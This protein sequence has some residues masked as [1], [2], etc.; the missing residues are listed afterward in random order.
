LNQNVA[1]GHAVNNPSVVVTFPTDESNASKSA[2]IQ[3]SLVTLQNLKGPG[4]GCPAASTTLLVSFA[5]RLP[6]SYSFKKKLY[7]NL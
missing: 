5:R 1:A 4:V 3:A 7:P 6:L 2:R